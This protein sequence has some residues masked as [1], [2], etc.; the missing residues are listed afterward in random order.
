MG[1]GAS[2]NTAVPSSI[3]PA[4]AAAKPIQSLPPSVV[5]SSHRIIVNQLFMVCNNRG[6][7]VDCLVS[8]A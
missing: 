4:A 3:P 5:D 1:C 7:L 6:Y 2:T 8:Q